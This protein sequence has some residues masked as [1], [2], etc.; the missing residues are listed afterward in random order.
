MEQVRPCYREVVPDQTLP[1]KWK[2]FTLN[3]GNSKP[4][5]YLTEI[6]RDLN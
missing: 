3:T 6:L 5:V 4:L 1:E 2:D